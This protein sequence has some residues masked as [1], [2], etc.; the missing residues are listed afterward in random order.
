MLA[1]GGLYLGEPYRTRHMLVGKAITRTC[2][3][4]YIRSASKL[5]PEKFQFDSQSEAKGIPPDTAYILR[6]EVIESYFILWR[7]THDP[8]YRE[9]GWEVVEALEKHCRVEGGGYSGL[10]DVN[11]DKPIKDDSQPSFFLAETLKVGDIQFKT[12]LL[13]YSNSVVSSDSTSTYYSV[14]MMSFL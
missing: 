11:D 13:L 14:T 4:S 8:I 10:K 7:L 12:V 3:E 6:P 9:W 1:L 5:G 2:H